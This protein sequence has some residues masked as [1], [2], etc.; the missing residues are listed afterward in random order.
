[1]RISDLYSAKGPVFSFEFF[2]PKTEKGFRSLYHTIGELRGLGPGFVSV[3]MGAG[4]STRSKTVDLVIDIERDLGL[5]A[6]THLP[7]VGF[8][9]ADVSGILATLG[10]AGMQNVLAL[11]GD[12]PRD[13]PD[14]VPA[15]DGFNHAAEIV[16]FLREDF[17]F[18]IGAAA[19]PE[20][21]PEAPDAET[22][23]RHLVAK[24]AA[25]SDFLIT[26]FFFDNA[27]YF[28]FCARAKAAGIEIPIVPGIMPITSTANVKRMASLGGGTL[29]PEL[30]AAIDAC[31]GD[32]ERTAELG[33]DWATSQ[34]RELLD[35]GAPGIHFYTLNRS[36]ATRRI[37]TSL[38]A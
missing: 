17:D 34:C 20:V 6:M 23:L 5:T 28:D 16:A 35:A 24:V 3:T 22:D 31:N 19:F 38:F 1:M 10:D 32:D 9:R 15:P 4:G 30:L 37:H 29:P 2:P 7:C 12:P 36:P 33:I 8:N 18:C 26:Q 25:G 13:A 21:H 27:A 14:F 11:R